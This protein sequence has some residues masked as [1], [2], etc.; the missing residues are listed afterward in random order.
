MY[1]NALSGKHKKCPA[2]FEVAGFLG[3]A[4]IGLEPMTL[5]V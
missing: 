3:V 4:Q 1:Q 2:T 5:R